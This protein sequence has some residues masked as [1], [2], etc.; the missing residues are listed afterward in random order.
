M[1]KIVI[2]LVIAAL[3]SLIFFACA[4]DAEEN[5][6]SNETN[7]SEATEPDGKKSH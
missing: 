1:R 5:G 4:T 2:I 6:L 7:L 3:T